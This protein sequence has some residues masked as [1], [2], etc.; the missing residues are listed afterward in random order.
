MW[1][2]VRSVPALAEGTGAAWN[3]GNPVSALGGLAAL[4]SLLRRKSAIGGW[5]LYFFLQVTIGSVYSAFQL[6]EFLLA[7][8]RPDGY[9]LLVIANAPPVVALASVVAVSIILTCTR[10]WKWIVPLRAALAILIGTRLVA[11]AIDAAY[12]P[13]KLAFDGLRIGFPAIYLGYFFVSERVD[14]VFRTRNW[15]APG[16]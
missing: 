10:E 14:R 15:G 5:L 1:A 9:D 8:P 13:D 12:F 2:L 16:N 4:V 6:I 7:N 11:I 3:P